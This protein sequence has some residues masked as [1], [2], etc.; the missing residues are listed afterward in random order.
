MEVT[1]EQTITSVE[2]VLGG[3]NEA[4]YVA[5]SWI[6]LQVNGFG[7][8]DVNSPV[9]SGEAVAKAIR[10]MFASGVTRFYPTVIT[11]SPED[12]TGAL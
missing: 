6:D 4:L 11:G 5:P 3:V 9:A 8:V 10:M 12:M 1:F 7:G 2:P